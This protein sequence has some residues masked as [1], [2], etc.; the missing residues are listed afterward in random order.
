MIIN[1]NKGLV[2]GC[3]FEKLVSPILFLISLYVYMFFANKSA[4]EII[5]HDNHIFVTV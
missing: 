3:N 4:Q 5:D 2:S 1:N